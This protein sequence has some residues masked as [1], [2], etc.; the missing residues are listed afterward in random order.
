[1]QAEDCAS[2][3]DVFLKM[4]VAAF[5]RVINHL[6][7]YVASLYRKSALFV[8]DAKPVSPEADLSGNGL[9]RYPSSGPG[10][11]P[12]TLPSEAALPLPLR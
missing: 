7:G 2:L 9:D 11:K 12:I 6:P 4:F 5:G 3:F 10:K 8:A 1:M